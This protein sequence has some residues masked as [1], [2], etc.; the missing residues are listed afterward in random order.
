VREEFHNFNSQRRQAARKLNRT[1]KQRLNKTLTPALLIFLISAG[2]VTFAAH[3]RTNTS[4]SRTRSRVRP[5]PRPTPTPRHALPKPVTGPRGFDQ[6]N[7]RD[8]S[9][10]LIAGAATRGV[11][12]ASNAYQD[13]ETAYATGKYPEAVAAFGEAVRSKPSWA[14][15]HYALALSL[16]E[17]GKLEDANREF[18]EVVKLKGAYQMVVLSYYNIGN[19]YA[20]LKKYLEAIE[21]YKLSIDLNPDISES[22]NNL[23]LAYSALG[24]VAEA[25][26]EF[27]RAI[28]LDPDYATARYNLGVAYLQTGRKQDAAGQQKALIKLDA[29]MASRLDGLIK[30]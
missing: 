24:R 4:Q 29:E 23:G 3:S 25:I 10:R 13:G 18:A 5:K 11:D 16:N 15:A 19:N 2:I 21:A 30:Q 1:V 28:K 7:Q 14:E 8:A 22:H 20:D 12:P 9:A 17:I 27:E 6:F 26:P